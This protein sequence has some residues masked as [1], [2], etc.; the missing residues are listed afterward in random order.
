LLI[1]LPAFTPRSR[2]RLPIRAVTLLALAA[3]AIT[4][5]DAPTAP[6]DGAGLRAARLDLA[7]SFPR[8]RRARTARS[9]RWASS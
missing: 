2:M 8:K 9:G 6:V 7:P 1:W 4:C 5:T 3:A